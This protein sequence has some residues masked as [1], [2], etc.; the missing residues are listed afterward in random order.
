MHATG[1]V[2]V[3]IPGVPSNLLQID[4]PLQFEG[5]CLWF[6]SNNSD[7]LLLDEIFRTAS[8]FDNKIA[9][10]KLEFLTI[11][12]IDLRMEAKIRGGSSAAVLPAFW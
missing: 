5:Y 11:I 8:V 10:W 4:P 9:G 12:S 3:V 1:S 2:N 7:V 6:A